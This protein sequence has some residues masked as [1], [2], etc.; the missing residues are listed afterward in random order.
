MIDEHERRL[1]DIEKRVKALERA[2]ERPAVSVEKYP[3]T[4][5]PG[6]PDGIYRWCACGREICRAPDCPSHKADPLGR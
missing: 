5:K 4:W 2:S 6:V 3:Q 1:D